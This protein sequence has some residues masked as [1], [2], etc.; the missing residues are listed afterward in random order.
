MIV[1]WF[2]DEPE[3]PEPERIRW[4]SAWASG[5]TI[6]TQG[7]Q[8]NTSPVATLIRQDRKLFSAIGAQ[9]SSLVRSTGKLLS[10]T[11]VTSAG[12]TWAFGL[13]LGAT[14]LPLATN[15]RSTGKFLQGTSLPAANLSRLTSKL[16][17]VAT[18]P[19][20]TLVAIRVFLVSS[21]ALAS[22]VATLIR[23]KTTAQSLLANAAAVAGLTY[24]SGKL[25]LANATISGTLSR[26][27]GK[28]FQGTSGPIAS[29]LRST[30]KFFSASASAIASLTSFI[31]QAIEPTRRFVLLLRNIAWALVRSFVSYNVIGQEVQGMPFFGTFPPVTP[32][33]KQTLSFDFGKFLPAGVTLTGT[34]T[35]TLTPIY[36]TDSNPA[37]RITSGPTIGTVSIALGGSGV[38]STGI[39]FQLF[40]CPAGVTYIVE[41][42][43]T[44]SDGD[45]AEGSSRLSSNSPGST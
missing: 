31:P 20:A 9:V 3:P 15:V 8:A 40:G 26:S 23:A 4:L 30:S 44:R 34:P 17:A 10:G 39:L 27:V 16:L 19:I 18:D 14:T 21:Q 33:Q 6:Y 25:L 36:G 11:G 1:N 32:L 13:P 2:V 45:I 24:V 38:T 22:A 43:C 35:L 42:V 5:G 7:A 29:A 28:N 37:S 41:T 12:M